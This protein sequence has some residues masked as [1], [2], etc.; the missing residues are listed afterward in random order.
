[1]DD[2]MRTEKDSV[3][4]FVGLAEEF[5]R[6]D[7][8][9]QAINYCKMALYQVPDMEEAKELLIKCYEKTGEKDKIAELRA[10]PRETEQKPHEEETER[11]LSPDDQEHQG[12][13]EP[14]EVH[15]E[16]QEVLSADQTEDRLESA[17][18]DINSIK[19]VLGSIIIEESGIIIKEK[20]VE[21][22]DA[23]IASA[24]FSTIFSVCEDS[25]EKLELGEVNRVFI[26]IGKVRI[27]LF[28][29]NGYII[30]IFTEEIVKIGLIHVRAKQLLKN[31]K[32][33]LGV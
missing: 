4:V 17:L 21:E 6:N 30:G 9:E 16:E 26:E 25:V 18:S 5:F 8:Y 32:E 27:Y 19:G 20:T 23:E 7:A 33:V 22:L 11:E 14:E 15:E 3:K 2:N 13:E 28:K 10:P 24:L 1:M 29:G 31:I 12:V